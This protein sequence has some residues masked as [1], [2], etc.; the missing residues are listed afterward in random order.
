MPEKKLI[1]LNDEDYIVEVEANAFKVSKNPNQ[2]PLT[3]EEVILVRREYD[4]GKGERIP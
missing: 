2:S 1:K 4:A 3:T